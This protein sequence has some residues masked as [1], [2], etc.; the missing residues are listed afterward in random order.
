MQWSAGWPR[1]DPAFAGLALM[2]WSPVVGP[3]ATAAEGDV[4]A[5]Q[6]LCLLSRLAAKLGAVGGERA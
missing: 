4:V 2:M 1:A 3:V 5:W 6:W